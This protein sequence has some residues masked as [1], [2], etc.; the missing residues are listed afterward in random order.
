MLSPLDKIE[1]LEG[2]MGYMKSIPSVVKN[3]VQHLTS[4][5]NSRRDCDPYTD[6]QISVLVQTSE[7]L[8]PKY[9]DDPCGITKMLLEEECAKYIG[10][11]VFDIG[12]VNIIPPIKTCCGPLKNTSAKVCTLFRKYAKP[13]VGIMHDMKCMKCNTVYRTSTYK[14][15]KQTEVYYMRMP[16]HYHISCPLEILYFQMISWNQLIRICK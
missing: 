4:L 13:V 5:M 10:K 7:E 14:K 8:I 1:D 16:V 2:I 12:I 9:G 3:R 15:T 6:S 11:G